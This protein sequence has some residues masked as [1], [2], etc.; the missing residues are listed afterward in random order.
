MPL[1][2]LT[3]LIFRL[4][5][6][7]LQTKDSVVVITLLT[8]IISSKQMNNRDNHFKI[9][10]TWKA[11][12]EKLI[13]QMFGGCGNQIHRKQFAKTYLKKE[14]FSNWFLVILRGLFSQDMPTE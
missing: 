12:A 3:K 5:N 7:V 10:S 13:N 2:Q 4:Y 11:Y 14:C 9:E 1:K 8:T 6:T